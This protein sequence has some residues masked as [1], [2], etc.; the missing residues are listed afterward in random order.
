MDKELEKIF[1]ES[2]YLDD[3]FLI[4]DDMFTGSIMEWDSL[5]HMNLIYNISNTYN[6]EIPFK[7]LKD[8]HN[9]GQLK[10]YVIKKTEK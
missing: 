1:L 5:S 8:I 10:E 6:I 4:K 2:L 7:D 9:W 3:D